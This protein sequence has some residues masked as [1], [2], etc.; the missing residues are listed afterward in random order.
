MYAL[1]KCYNGVHYVYLTSLEN[2][3]MLSVHYILSNIYNTKTRDTKDNDYHKNI[4]V[5]TSQ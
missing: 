4:F 2:V 1:V 5:S 3:T